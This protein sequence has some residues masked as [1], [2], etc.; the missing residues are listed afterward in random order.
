MAEDVREVV[1]NQLKT[2]VSRGNQPYETT[3]DPVV[4]DLLRQILAGINRISLQI[5]AETSGIDGVEDAEG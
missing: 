3:G 5:A 1:E 2:H 4:H